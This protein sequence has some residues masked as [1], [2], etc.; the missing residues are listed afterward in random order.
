MTRKKV[1]DFAKNAASQTERS[2][3]RIARE[4]RKYGG[5][6]MLMSQTIRDF[7]YELA[8]LRQM[9]NTKIFLRNSDR[10]IEYAADIIGDGRA[11]VQL[12]TGTALVHNANWGLHRIR[13]RPPLSKVYELPESAIKELIGGANENA[14]GLTAEAERLLSAI[15]SYLLAGNSPLNISKAGELVGITSRRKLVELIAELEQS[16]VIYTRQLAERGK[17]RVIELRN[18][19]TG[20]QQ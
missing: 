8:S 14:V 11:L 13:V 16:G 20:G 7:S 6:L 1:D 4:G 3:D 5:M 18:P 15:K 17:P 19:S 9:T 2:L 12:P 10:E